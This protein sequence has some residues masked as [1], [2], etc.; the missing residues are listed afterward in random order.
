[1]AKRSIIGLVAA[2]ALAAPLW[3]ASGCSESS[4]ANDTAT[5][6]GCE[7]S[8]TGEC[9][10]TPCAQS[11]SAACG[12]HPDLCTPDSWP[13]DST[14][15]CSPAYFSVGVASG[16]GNYS[17]ARLSY[18]DR[19]TTAYYD[20]KTGALVALVSHDYVFQT[21]K[22]LG[23]DAQFVEPTCPSWTTVHCT[24]ADASGSTDAS[25]GG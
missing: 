10:W 24:S 1:M 3:A 5:D 20:Q 12:A 18:A 4:D 13:A 14:A 6:A 7:Q 22:C 21:A 15:F 2:C 19:G 8:A 11:V 16:C 9:A 23:G 17:A 25:D